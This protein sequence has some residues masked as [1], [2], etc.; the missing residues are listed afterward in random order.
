MLELKIITAQNYDEENNKFIYEATVVELEHSLFSLSLWEEKFRRPFFDTEKS[1]EEVLWYIKAMCRTENV[2]DE[3]WNFLSEENSKAISDYLGDTPTATWFSDRPG[4]NRKG[5]KVT[6]E[7][8]YYAMYKNNIPGEWEHR[9][10][11]RLMTLLRVFYEK[12]APPQ[13]MSA[14]DRAAQQRELNRQ[15]REQSGSKG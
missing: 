8:I 4:A 3:V 13:K 9:N 11:F 12:E 5:E 1:P 6:S 7:V 14:R 10:L 2:P 15:R